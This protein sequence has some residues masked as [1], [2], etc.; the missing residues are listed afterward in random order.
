MALQLEFTAPNGVTANQ[1]YAFIKSLTEIDGS[2]ISFQ[3]YT[4]YTK[5]AKEN[6][7]EP[8]FTRSYSFTPDVSDE[9]KNYRKQG[10]EF[11][12]TIEEFATALDVLEEGQSPL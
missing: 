2:S 12:K 11:L 8:L 4:Y 6:E 9:A 3:L 10:Y 7:L 1:A 5:E